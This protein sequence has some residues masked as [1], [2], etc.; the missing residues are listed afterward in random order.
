MP[1]LVLYVSLV[2][3]IPVPVIYLL[4]KRRQLFEQ[5]TKLRADAEGQIAGLQ[6]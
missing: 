6:R 1:F 4:V 5:A 2:L 3:L